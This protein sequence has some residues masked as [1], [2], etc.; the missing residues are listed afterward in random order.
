MSETELF[1]MLSTD[2]RYGGCVEVRVRVIDETPT[3]YRIQAIEPC[4]LGRKWLAR[5]CDTLVLKKRVRILGGD[6]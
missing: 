3:R 4:H 6:Q 1:G 5:N 2:G